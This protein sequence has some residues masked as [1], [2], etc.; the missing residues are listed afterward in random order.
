MKIKF[1]HVT[2][3][4]FVLVGLQ[5]CVRKYYMIWR[6]I[7]SPDGGCQDASNRVAT[8]SPCTHGAHPQ[9]LIVD[10]IFE[11]IKFIYFNLFTE[12]L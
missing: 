11:L 10:D 8:R 7:V 1:I 6:G 9:F 5:T 2:R 4:C 3:Q 12:K